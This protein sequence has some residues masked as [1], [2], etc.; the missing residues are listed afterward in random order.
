MVEVG[1]V[2]FDIMRDKLCV[3]F[4]IKDFIILM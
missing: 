4:V 3:G 1:L 2:L